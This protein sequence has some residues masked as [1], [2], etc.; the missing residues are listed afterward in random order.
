M[1]DD[2]PLLPRQGWQLQI[3]TRDRAHIFWCRPLLP[4]LNYEDITT[5]MENIDA[6]V[7]G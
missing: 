1:G 2:G 5:F 4:V 3:Q 7:T 6:P